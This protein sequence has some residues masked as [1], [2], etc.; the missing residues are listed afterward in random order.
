MLGIAPE[1]RQ[2]KL[3][4]KQL[5]PTSI[6]EYIA[7]HKPGDVVSGRVVDEIGRSGIGG[8]GERTSSQS[9]TWVKWRRPLQEAT[10]RA[11]ARS[12]LADIIAAG[13]LEGKF[14]GSL[15]SAGAAAGGS[16]SQF[17]DHEARR[18]VEDAVEV[19]VA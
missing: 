19:Q 12:L 6:D 3:S 13:A 14:S 2:I 17:Q 16:D 18:R 10:P 8:V 11:G 15:G 9:A 4:M 5:V 1:K 7:E